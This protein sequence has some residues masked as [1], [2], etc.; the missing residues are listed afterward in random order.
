M[1]PR[2]ERRQSDCRGTAANDDDDK[3]DGTRHRDVLDANLNRAVRNVIVITNLSADHAYLPLSLVELAGIR[4]E[5]GMDG[6]A[7]RPAVADC[8]RHVASGPATR[9][10]QRNF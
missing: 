1:S 4:S 3:G 6:A 7:G 5:I 8:D 10:W 9:N 2:A